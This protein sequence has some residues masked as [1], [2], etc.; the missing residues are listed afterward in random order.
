LILAGLK[1]ADE[2]LLAM[3][4]KIHSLIDTPKLQD[5]LPW[6]EQVTDSSAGDFQPV[7][8]RAIA[9]ALANVNPYTLTNANA[10]TIGNFIDYIQWSER[11]QVYQDIDSSEL[12]ATLEKLKQ[13]IPD[14][15]ESI[16]VRQAFGQRIIQIWLT[17]FHLTPEMLDLS[18][19]ELKALDNYF[20]ANL[21]MVECKKA[22]VRVSP[23]TWEGI[24][25]RMLLPARN[26]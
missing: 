8:K 19:S 4:Q 3:E 10:Y 2:L 1:R 5:L 25:S 6:V 13:E 7:G 17:A 9:L 20:Y 14:H 22:A 16:E 23:A 12:I 26:I 21:L 11:F 18:K 15:K 24:E